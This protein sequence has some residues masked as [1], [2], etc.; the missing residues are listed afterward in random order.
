MMNNDRHEQEPLVLA[1]RLVAQLEA[2]DDEGIQ[3]TLDA[4][5]RIREAELFRELGVLTRD[6]HEA[7]KSFQ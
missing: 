1:R 6:L 3:Q 7:L 2:G 5:A 4:L